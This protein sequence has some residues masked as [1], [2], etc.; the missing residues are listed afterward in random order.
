[1]YAYLV[2][3]SQQV[4]TMG[5]GNGNKR[6][7]RTIQRTCRSIATKWSTKKR[8]WEG[9]KIERACTCSCFGYCSL[10]KIMSLCKIILLMRQITVFRIPED[11]TE[12]VRSMIQGKTELS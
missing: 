9:A 6:N 2:A 8:I 1:M 12:H 7:E 4:S 5:E 10:C 11:K 3:C